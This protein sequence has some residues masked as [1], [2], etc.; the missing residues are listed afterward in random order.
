M[1]PAEREPQDEH[2]RQAEEEL[3]ALRLAFGV[4]QRMVRDEFPS[5]HT[6]TEI[7]YIWGH[8]TPTEV[9]AVRRLER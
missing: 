5:E 4:L 6:L 7:V 8:A 1:V 9:D 2:G 3:R